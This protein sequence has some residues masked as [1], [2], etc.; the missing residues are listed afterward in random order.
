M[1][2]HDPKADPRFDRLCESFRAA[3]LRD[4]PPW[5]T[6]DKRDALTLD[7]D[8]SQHRKYHSL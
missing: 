2:D 6:D 1:T 5:Q 7:K 8:G 4:D 3:T